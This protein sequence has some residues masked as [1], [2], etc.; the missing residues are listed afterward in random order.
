MATLQEVKQLAESRGARRVDLKVTDLLGRWQ[1]FSMPIDRFT[2]ELAA[3]GLGFDGSSLRG[4]QPIEDSDMLLVPDLETAAFDP[5]PQ[6]P[7]LSLICDVVDPITRER[8]SRD[9]RYVAEKAEAH[10]RTTALADTAYFGPELEFFIFDDVRFQQTPNTSFYFVDSSEADWN[11][12]RDEAPNLGYKVPSKAGYSPTPP[13][14]SHSELRWA[15][16]EALESVGLTVEV[17]HHEVATG[18]Q[19]EIA[20]TYR[21]LRHKADEVQWYKYLVQN[22]ARAFGQVATFMPKPVYGD[23]GSGMHTHQSLWH[24][25]NPIFFDSNGYAGLSQAARYYIGGLLRHAPAVLAF[26]SPSTNSYKRLVPGFEA[27]VN[28]VYSVRNRSA[29]VR[30]PTYSQS[31]AAKRIEF[32]PPDGTA[33]PYLAFA[34]MLMAGLDGIQSRIDPGDPLDKNI[35]ELPPEDARRLATVPPTLDAALDALEKDCDFLKKGDVFT[36]D[37]IER[38]IEF[39]R[40]EVLGLNARPTA[41]EYELYFNG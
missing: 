13:F 16:V 21:T 32:R 3:E 38:W 41:Y 39:K 28:L 24:D 36:Q 33:N 20:T 40:A 8:Y 7:T 6:H 34:A 19:G 18:G 23:N 27:P 26:A 10:L 12:G 14:D 1:H 35:Y 5:V 30:I 22:V 37:L 25:D 9:P 31:G 15:V 11:S 17:S 2:P 29:A 4:F